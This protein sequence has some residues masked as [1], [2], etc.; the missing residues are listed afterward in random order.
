MCYVD[1]QSEDDTSSEDETHFAHF[2]RYESS[3]QTS[4]SIT[5]SHY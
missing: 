1:H 5:S 4:E 3:Q 2:S